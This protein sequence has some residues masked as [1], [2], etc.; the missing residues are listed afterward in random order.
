VNITV[1]DEPRELS[2]Q[3]TVAQLLELLGIPPRGVAVEV[4]SQVV[5]RVRHC[6]HLL[7]DGDKLEIVKLVGGG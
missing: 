2:V 7:N 3:L 4:N 1:N 6:E 5:P